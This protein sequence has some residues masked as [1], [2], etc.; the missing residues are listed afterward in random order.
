[1]AVRERIC[2]EALG[3]GLQPTRAIE[4]LPVLTVTNRHAAHMPEK[5]LRRVGDGLIQ[6]AYR[7][8]ATVVPP[9]D[10][11]ECV[12]QGASEEGLYRLILT[13]KGALYLRERL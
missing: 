12:R 8:D 10:R 6:F 11:L 13:L 1:M 9:R 4:Y 5:D 3:G 7:L 2:T